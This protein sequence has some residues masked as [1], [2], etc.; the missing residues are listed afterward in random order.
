MKISLELFNRV[1]LTAVQILFPLLA[2]GFCQSALAL[3]APAE[4]QIIV[5]RK[6]PIADVP[7]SATLAAHGGRERGTVREINARI[8]T[9]P[10]AQ[11]SQL[12]AGLQ[13][14]SDTQYVEVDGVAKA[15]ATVNDPLFTQGQEWHLAKIQAPA[16]WDITT[17]GSNVIIAVVDSGV[18]PSH[19]DLAGKVLTNGWDFVANNANPVDQNGHGTAVAGTISP[20]ANNNLGVVGVAW[21]NSILP[22]RVLDA[23]GSGSYSAIAQGITYAANQGARIINLSLGGTSFSQ[24]LQDAI[25]YAWSKQCIVVAS[26]GNNGNSVLVYPAACNNVVSVAATNASDT[27]P[28]WS[29]YGSYIDVCAPGEN[30]MT[31][32]GSNGYGLWSGTSFSAPVTSGILALM[33]SANPSLTNAQL[34]D[35]LLK[36]C[37]D[38]GTSGPD[39]YY[40]NGRVNALRAVS[41]A[42][43]YTTTDT[44]P[45]VATLLSPGNGSTI[46]GT[47]NVSVKATD[48]VG[49]TRVELYVDA[50]LIAQ[51]GSASAVF[52]LNTLSY[53]NGTHTLQARAYDAKGN[54]GTASVSVTVKNSAA[55]TVAPVTAI[56]SPANGSTIASPYQSV[57]VTCT[58]N[59]RATKLEIYL[60][61]VLAGVASANSLP[62]ALTFIWYTSQ[63][64]KG[65]HT[66][67]TYAYDAA[68]NIGQS[69]VITLVK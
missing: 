35:L 66:L 47:T 39:I 27:R 22:V 4:V 50:K 21:A 69:A 68:G 42:K 63:L 17:G 33:A 53:A 13:N 9:V 26:A 58:D 60:D 28:S 67:Q 23:N 6:T 1:S 8:I 34:V 15:H 29:N 37:D 3:P 62:S 43:T 64:S 41:A 2:L 55:D 40:G 16:A 54:V 48:N 52:P 11:A 49:V 18:N 46:S 57:S 20:D 36:N 56:T 38:L 24:T 10:A 51:S 31:L 5:K 61:G 59:V 45:P 7:Y 19:P 32:S 25:N 65:N 44:I 12:I 30:I 14:Q